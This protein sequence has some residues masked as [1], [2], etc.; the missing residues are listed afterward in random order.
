MNVRSKKNHS[1]QTFPRIG[2]GIGL[3]PKHWNQILEQKPSI[4][5][6]EIISENFMDTHGKP[7]RVLEK[8]R[9]NYPV[10]CHGVSL[11]IGSS[12]PLNTEYL[13][14]LKTLADKI[15]PVWVSDHLCWT[16]VERHNSFDLLP[17]PQTDLVVKHI[18]DRIQQVQEFLQR[19]IVIENV[20]SYV[21]FKES[22]MHEWEFITEIAK[23][24]GC[25]ILLDINNVY[26]NAFNHNFDAKKYIE[27]IPSEHLAQFHLAGHTNRGTFLFDTHSAAMIEPVWDLYRFA[28]QHFG[29]IPTLVEWDQDIPELEVLL[30]ERKKAM[31]I[32]KSVLA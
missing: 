18:V 3:R 10:V 23:R 16:G 13:K 11:S 28:V 14:N 8:I 6:F 20:S 24:S 5:W 19:R 7:M 32:E 26:V 30:D 31:E 25:G 21:S 27:H 17:L 29:K 1:A 2:H 9:E 12:D 22:D 4:D 15:E